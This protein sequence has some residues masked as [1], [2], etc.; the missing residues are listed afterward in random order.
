[1]RRGAWR[2]CT[3][4]DCYIRRSSVGNEGAVGDTSLPYELFQ[5]FGVVVDRQIRKETREGWEGEK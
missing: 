1:V 3:S 4:P 5:E 2:V